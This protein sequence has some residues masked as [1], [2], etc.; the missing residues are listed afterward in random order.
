MWGISPLTSHYGGLVYKVQNGNSHYWQ[1][2][3]RWLKNLLLE[4]PCQE[5]F[6]LTLT[7]VNLMG[8]IYGYYWYAGQLASTPFIWW[9]FIPDSP[10]ATTLFAL[11]LLL[12]YYRRENGALRLIAAAAVIK[13]G[14]WAVVVISDYW[15]AG[16]PLTAVEA[17]LWLSHLGML[18][19]GGLF[20]RHWPA[21]RRQLPL[22]VLWLGLNDFIDYGLGLHPYLFSPGQEALAL[23]AAAS[24]SLGLILYLVWIIN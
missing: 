22:V 2:L 6:L 3:Y 4:D 1:A 8:S 20:L 19:E 12:A 21:T 11:A 9:P 13:Y 16:A 5:W 23:A 14:L 18:I 17:G 7:A 24:L 10:L 15:L